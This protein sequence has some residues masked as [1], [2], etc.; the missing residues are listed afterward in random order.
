M[1]KNNYQ[2]TIDYFLKILNFN[3]YKKI[4]EDASEKQLYT[5]SYLNDVR[6]GQLTESVY[7]KLRNEEEKH[8]NN[9][10]KIAIIPKVFEK[11]LIDQKEDCEK[12]HEN[13]I[14]I[15]P[16]YISTNME[17][18][19]T[20]DLAEAKPIWAT[21]LEAP[22]NVDNVSFVKHD[23]DG[24]YDNTSWERFM[25]SVQQ[26]YEKRYGISWDSTEI[27]D[28]DNN[29]HPIKVLMKEGKQSCWIMR[30]DA[31]TGT[32]KQIINLLQRLNNHPE[33]INGLF[34][35]MLGKPVIPSTGEPQLGINV[36]EH[37]GQ[38][39]NE[40]PLADS[41]RHAIHCMGNLTDGNVLA[42]SGPPG[43]GKTTMLQSVVADLIVK[44]ALMEKP[45]PPVI[46]ATSANNKA[47]TNIIDAFKID[48]ESK[49]ASPLFTRWLK[50]NDSPLPLAVYLPS[51]MAKEKDKFFCSTETGGGD[52]MLLK[53]QHTECMN[54]F[55][56]MAKKSSITNESNICSI[57]QQLLKQL[58]QSNCLLK[59]FEKSLE[60]PKQES[61][62]GIWQNLMT[63]FACNS[64]TKMTKK[65]M[66]EYLFEEAINYSAKLKTLNKDIEQEVDSD[67]K[68]RLE[69]EKDA[70]IIELHY[71]DGVPF[72]EY[73][74]K[75]LDRCLRFKCFWLA[76]H[77]FE[78]CW[79][80]KVK[81]NLRKDLSKLY[82]S[83]IYKEMSLVC[84][85]IVATF[86]RAP[87]CFKK[88]NNAQEGTG[89]LYDYI[90]LLIVDEAGQA[91]TEIGIP[92][93]SLAK[94]A[95][96]VGD[97]CQIPP[98]YSIK[99]GTSRKYWESEV[100]NTDVRSFELLDS[101]DSSV[102]RVASKQSAFKR[103]WIN[104]M[105]NR[106]E[107]EGLFLDEHRRCYDD[108]IAYCNKLIYNGKLKPLVGNPK[109][110]ESVLPVMG[111]LYI[112]HSKSETTP[113]GS[114]KSI[115][116]ARAIAQWIKLNEDIIRKENKGKELKDCVSV[117]TPFT[118]QAKLIKEELGKV[119]YIYNEKDKGIP[120]G[121]VHTFQGA[122]SP[123]VI[124]STVYG[125][126]DGKFSFVDGNEKLMNVA[127]SR[128]KKHFFL[129]SSKK[130]EEADQNSNSPFNLLLK[131]TPSIVQ[132]DYSISSKTNQIK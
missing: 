30:E 70:Y 88:N 10:I 127:V 16:F 37:R 128:A 31:V 82:R 29:T 81:D 67:K 11:I 74:D 117:I 47:I 129:F 92:T 33:E 25:D 51:E 4:R 130:S 19:G 84:P 9:P 55:V 100:G 79:L 38:M 106:E 34:K 2:K 89:Y 123:I 49:V 115:D 96:V 3:E 97:E 1:G 99:T 71:E 32:T 62:P 40:Y 113:E 112:P 54:Y 98:I 53:K 15:S 59:R 60:S 101:S 68:R 6:K 114:R 94:K 87:K 27:K 28:C 119:G 5:Y 110:G 41:Q 35:T 45:E 58:K 124:Y 104:E 18:N 85:C 50:F 42:V 20:L 43:T 120:V 132:N 80:E 72:K 125:F 107:L 108:I 48:E 57:K 93:F 86:F 63:F 39:K 66:E 21:C 73:V 52:Y 56:E 109:E 111:H 118:L 8:R 13:F 24:S 61:K 7:N 12:S 65:E 83:E 14:P 22:C 102:M 91:C 76:V 75:M 90:D 121:T 44:H 116:E 64:H 17:A 103:I 95:I 131:M 23:V 122:E 26:H 78:A 69:E 36:A 105:G 126:D 46:L 77:Y